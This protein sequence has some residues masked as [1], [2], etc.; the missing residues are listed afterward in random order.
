MLRVKCTRVKKEFEVCFVLF[1]RLQ[2]HRHLFKKRRIDQN[3]YQNFK[4]NDIKGRKRNEW[5]QKLVW[6]K[7]LDFTSVCVM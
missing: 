4:K 7:Y 1:Q 3:L 2:Y 6:R 5:Y